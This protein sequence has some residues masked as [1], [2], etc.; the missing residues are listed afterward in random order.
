M[1]RPKIRGGS[2]A[3]FPVQICLV[4]A[5]YQARV[6]SW[7]AVKVYFSLWIIKSTRCKPQK[8]GQPV[9]FQ[10]SE[11]QKFLKGVTQKAIDTALQELEAVNLIKFSEA[12]IWFAEHF[13][14]LSNDQV[15]TCAHEMFEQLHPS[16]RIKRMSFPRRILKLIIRSGQK[17]V[18]VATL[19][20]L[21]LRTML[22]KLYD[23]YKGCVKASWIADLFGVSR[24]RVRIERSKLIE[25]EIFTRISTPQQVKNRY[26]EWIALNLGI[27]ESTPP[28][29]NTTETLPNFTQ[30]CCRHFWSLA[31]WRLTRG[32]PAPPVASVRP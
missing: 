31:A 6:I 11:I 23:V 3:I 5:A 20:G 10:T 7:L 9:R 18:R 24:H 26:G 21:L 32:S 2:C 22:T 15:K 25:E 12:E 4:W 27:A 1:T 8:E 19:L 30:S 13:E 29:E 16:T 28:V 14:D 17:V